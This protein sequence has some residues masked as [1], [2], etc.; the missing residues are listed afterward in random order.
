MQSLFGT[1]DVKRFFSFLP[2]FWFL[3]ILLLG[4]IEYAGVVFAGAWHVVTILL[5]ICLLI[6]TAFLVRQLFHRKIWVSFI[7]G[8]VFLLISFYLS[9]ALFSELKEFPNLTEPKAIEMMSGGGILIGGS[10]AMSVLMMMR[11]TF[12]R[13][14]CQ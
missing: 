14:T 1:W 9:L 5:G 12:D 13:N 4:W 11:N 7:L 8:F 10:L 3:T 6:L 2:D